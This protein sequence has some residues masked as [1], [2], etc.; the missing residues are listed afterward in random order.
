MLHTSKSKDWTG[1]FC[2]EFEGSRAYPRF[3]AMTAAEARPWI[4][5]RTGPKGGRNYKRCQRCAP[6]V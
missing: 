4:T 1:N 2:D 3:E 5:A 6:T